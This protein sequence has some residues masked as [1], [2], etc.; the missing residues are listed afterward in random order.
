[1][2]PYSIPIT[3]L[4]PMTDIGQNSPKQFIP[5]SRD[6]RVDSKADVWTVFGAVRRHQR[7][8]GGSSERQA[9]RTV[10]SSGQLPRT[11]PRIFAMRFDVAYCHNGRQQGGASGR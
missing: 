5:I 2:T 9:M 7:A 8:G 6:D 4:Q 1:M 3:A 10:N 11:R